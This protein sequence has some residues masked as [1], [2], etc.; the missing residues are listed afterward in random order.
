M[1]EPAHPQFQRSEVLG[2]VAGFGTTFCRRAR[3][4]HHAQA[5][6]VQGYEPDDGS[7]QGVFQIL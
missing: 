6:L 4:D 5:A 2:F 1:N 3:L 7:Y